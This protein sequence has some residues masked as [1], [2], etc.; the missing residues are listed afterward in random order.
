MVITVGTL[1]NSEYKPESPYVVTHMGVINDFNCSQV[2]LLEDVMGKKLTIG[3]VREKVEEA[4]YKLLSDMYVN[5]SSKLKFKCPICNQIFY[6]TYQNFGAGR[7][8]RKCSYA[9]RDEKQRF[10]IENIREELKDIDRLYI[11]LADVYVNSHIK[12]PFK[13]VNPNHTLFWMS[14][15]AFK[16]AGNRCPECYNSVRGATQKLKIEDIKKEMKIIAPK[17]IL[18]AETYINSQAKMPFRCPN[19]NEIFWMSWANFKFSKQRCSICAGNK[20]LTLKSIK[21]KMDSIAP[22]YKLLAKEYINSQTKMP[23]SCPDCTHNIFWMSWA[24]FRNN[25]RCSQC[26]SNK[27]T[28]EFIKEETMKIAIGYKCLADVYVNTQTK[29]L[30]ICD[31][32]HQFEA[33]W[34][35]FSNHTRCPRCWEER[36]I[37]HDEESLQNVAWYRSVITRYSNENFNKYGYLINPNKL[38][39][40]EGYHLDHIYSVRDGFNNGI[41]PQIIASPTNLQLLSS[42]DNQSK[43]RRSDMTKEELFEKYSEFN[44]EEEND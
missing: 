11:C 6:M 4:G 3:Y 32:G 36:R 1:I 31:Q 12:M 42:I 23:F 17:Y 40:G 13:C 29:M 37:I 28:L 26:R 16:H 24:D 2:F 30:F 5:N 33:T 43:N 8:C 41:L 10:K 22:V 25:R 34:S 44:K 21:E 18:L 14:W 38:E 9:K 27:L 19:C 7:R 20:K 39:R 35:N 15:T